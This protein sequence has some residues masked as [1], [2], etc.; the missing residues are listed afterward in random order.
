M[1]YKELII[2]LTTNFIFSMCLF[3]YKRNHH[4]H[5]DT[6][7]NRLDNIEHQLSYNNIINDKYFNRKD[8]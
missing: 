1:F 7:L 5:Y 2:S 8:F 6:I 4:Y 3:I